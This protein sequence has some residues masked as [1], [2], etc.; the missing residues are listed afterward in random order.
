MKHSWEWV[1]SLRYELDVYCGRRAWK[2]TFL[3]YLLC[4]FFY[5]SAIVCLLLGLDASD[6]PS[7]VVRYICSINGAEKY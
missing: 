2:W 5:L 7:C 6:P 3:P 4:R 1:T